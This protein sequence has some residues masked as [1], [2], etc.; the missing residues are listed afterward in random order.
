[1]S[2]PRKDLQGIF[3]ILDRQHSKRIRLEQIRGVASLL[4][5]EE[6]AE[7]KALIGGSDEQ[8]LEDDLNDVYERVKE[9]L[10]AHNTTME[11]IIYGELKFLPTQLATVNYLNQVFGKFEIVLPRA[12]AERILSNLRKANHG[13]FECSIK[14]F[15]EYMT[16][17]RVNIA[18]VDK[19]FIDPLIAQCCQYLNKAKDQIGVTFETLFEIFAGAV[20]GQATLQKDRFL[21]C[22]QGLE[23]DIPQEDLIELFNY[24]DTS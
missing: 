16:R 23:M 12:D 20:G 1:M 19:G 5:S 8:D 7:K 24:M 13:K 4:S 11:A 2:I 6:E 3:G 10:E 22:V 17:K 9:Y 18:F 21:V 14:H 15:I